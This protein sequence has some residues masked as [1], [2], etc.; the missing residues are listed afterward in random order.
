MNEEKDA[1]DE[2]QVLSRLGEPARPV[3]QIFASLLLH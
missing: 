2:G 3:A 1:N